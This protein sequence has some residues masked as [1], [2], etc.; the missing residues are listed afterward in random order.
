MCYRCETR[1]CEKR[2][3]TWTDRRIK[4]DVTNRKIKQRKERV[5]GEVEET[6]TKK[7]KG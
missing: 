2:A 7:I 3:N 5:K 4:L 6:G 1:Q